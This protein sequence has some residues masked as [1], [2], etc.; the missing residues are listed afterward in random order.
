MKKTPNKIRC[1]PLGTIQKSDDGVGYHI[2]PSNHG[3][4][5]P[6]GDQIVILDDEIPQLFVN[7]LNLLLLKL[8]AKKKKKP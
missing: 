3:E 1:Y 7:L 4:A 5:V 2:L 8:L 6:S